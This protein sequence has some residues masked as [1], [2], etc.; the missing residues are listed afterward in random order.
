LGIGDD[1]HYQSVLMDCIR[2]YGSN[3][4]LSRVNNVRLNV[5]EEFEFF[6]AKK[7]TAEDATLMSSGYLAGI[8]ASQY[9]FPL[10]DLCWVA[11]DTHP[12]IL[13]FH[14][15]GD[16]QLNFIQWK[17]HCLECSESINS[18]KILIIGNAVDP[19]RA[20][21]H[22]YSWVHQVAKKHEVTLL[23]DDSHSFGVLGESLFGTYSQNDLPNVDLLVSG[24]LGKGLEMP[25]GIILGK[26]KHVGQIKSQ[27][28]FAGAS[29]PSPANLQAFLETQDIQMLLSQKIRD[30]SG[31]F[32]Q[33]TQDLSTVSG[34]ARF[35][36]FLLNDPTWS[37]R[38]E[39]MGFITS[40]FSY[41]TPDSPRISRIVLS[42]FHSLV[43]LMALNEAV[44]H[45]SGKP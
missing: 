23:I 18:Q 8:A 14:L 33:E 22:D 3:H 42:G 37:D 36:V 9:L 39:K 20:E 15:K 10:S 44:H 29:P 41:P 43:D 5:Y 4:G 11:P 34:T 38:L 28:I 6:F 17:N 2:R 16:F 45:L 21:V 12:A 31:I 27:A 24:S 19:L 26:K 1:P 35:P 40:S 30:F 32:Y 13:P 25:A 7:A